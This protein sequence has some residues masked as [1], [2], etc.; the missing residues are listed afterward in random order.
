M[1]K[2][3]FFQN[4]G[5]TVYESKILASFTKLKK[6]NAKELSQDSGVPV[7]KIYKT[8]RDFESLGLIEN[9]PSENKTFKLLNLKTFVANKIKEKESSLREI[10]KHSKTVEIVDKNEFVFSLIKGQKSI[11]DKLAEHNPKVKKQIL[12]VQRNWKVWGTG[13]REMQKTV[14]KGVDVKIIGVV[15]KETKSRALEWKKTG[16]KI[17]AYNKAYGEYPLRFT[18]FDNK[19]ARITIGKPEIPNP[20]NYVT[21]WTKSKPLIAILRNQFLDMWKN[22]IPINK[23][24]K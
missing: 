11:M 2:E 5:L 21:V 19:E 17:R 14:R 4:L 16:A 3:L 7:N 20:E 9:L 1:D 23:A 13:L 22:S 24:L 12:G 15:N 10:K 6:A 18:I 8:L